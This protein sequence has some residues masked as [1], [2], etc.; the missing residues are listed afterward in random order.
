MTAMNLQVLD[1]METLAREFSFDPL[2]FDWISN[3]RA[4]LRPRTPQE[5][6]REFDGL[7]RRRYTENELM[8][9]VD[10]MS[11]DHAEELRQFLLASHPEVMGDYIE[12]YG[13]MKFSGSKSD[14]WE[15]GNRVYE[16]WREFL[17]DGILIRCQLLAL[18]SNIL[19]DGS[20]YVV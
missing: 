15:Y 5:L 12:G 17:E 18:S 1:Q 19:H 16:V 14:V 9:G 7:R 3:Q 20:E 8:R 11:A 6:R 4:Q 10:D 2:V 13:C